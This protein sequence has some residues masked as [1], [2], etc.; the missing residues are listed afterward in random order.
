MSERRYRRC[1]NCGARATCRGVGEH[2]GFDACDDCCDHDDADVCAAATPSRHDALMNSV[3]GEELKDAYLAACAENDR[4]LAAIGAARRDLLEHVGD[5]C[6]GPRGDARR[7]ACRACSI[8]EELG[9]AAKPPAVVLTRDQ[10]RALLAEGRE[11]R[12]AAEARRASLAIDGPKRK[13]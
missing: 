6:A 4:L 9:R 8:A 1:G 7:G 13:L 2:A 11:G 5:G 3:S 12:Y 10:V